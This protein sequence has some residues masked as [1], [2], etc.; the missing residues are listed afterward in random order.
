MKAT[1]EKLENN[2]VSLEVEVAA[3]KFSEAV[4]Q[5]FKKISKKVNIPG[6]RKG[7]APRVVMERY[8]NKEAVYDEAIEIAIPDA[9]GDAVEDTGIEPVAQPEVELVQVEDGKALIFKAMVVVKPEVELGQ[10]FDIEVKALNIEVTDEDVENELKRLQNR[11]AKLITIEE[12]IV[13]K[14]DMTVIDFE[15]KIDGVPFDGGKAEDYNL[16]IGSGAFIPGFEESVVGMA[17]GEERDVN[18]SFPEDYG[19]EELS[20]KPVVFSVKVKSLKRKE[21]SALDDEFVKDISE[22]DTLDELKKDVKENLEK[23]AEAREKTNSRSQAL[24]K[25]IENAKVDIPVE[26]IDNRVDE[27]IENMGQR[28][29]TQGFDLEKYLSYTNSTEEELREKIRPD[30]EVSVRENLVLDAVIKAEN[31]VVSEEELMEE[32]TRMSVEM[33]QDPEMIRKVIEAQNQIEAMKLN[34]LRERVIEVLG[35]KAVIV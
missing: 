31:M 18:I 16:E 28:M 22:F 19:N 24:A 17:V 7:K 3:E 20:G 35:E 1:V 27:M 10:Y 8:I 33:K 14:G 6:F 15:G 2:K 30:A 13:E 34:M 23:A 9:Y 25:A 12:G 32:I 5:A 4:D 29:V 11:H 26:M 21:L